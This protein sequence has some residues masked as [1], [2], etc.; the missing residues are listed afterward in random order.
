MVY[1]EPWTR[2]LLHPRWQELTNLCSEIDKLQEKA[3]FLRKQIDEDLD[4]YSDDE[5]ENKK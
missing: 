4:K 5:L 2:H 1:G 3:K